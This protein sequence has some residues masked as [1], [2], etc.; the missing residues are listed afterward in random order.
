MNSSQ[1][2]IGCVRGD[3][4]L[5]ALGLSAS[6]S[7]FIVVLFVVAHLLYPPVPDSTE[8]PSVEAELEHNLSAIKGRLLSLG[9]HPNINAAG[10][11]NN[12]EYQRLVQRAEVCHDCWQ[13]SE[14]SES[15]AAR[16]ISF[17]IVVRV[18]APL[19]AF[20]QLYVVVGKITAKGNEY[21]GRPAEYTVM[22]RRV[23]YAKDQLGWVRI[24]GKGFRF[25]PDNSQGVWYPWHSQSPQMRL[26]GR[27]AEKVSMAV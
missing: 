18:P 11:V 3:I 25:R 2:P 12:S 13:L 7:A 5:L 1:E 14:R 20:Q 15:S 8:S 19:H 22:P 10:L 21:L 23:I 6:H 9:M 4:A 26:E 27:L 17:P 16:T 24:R